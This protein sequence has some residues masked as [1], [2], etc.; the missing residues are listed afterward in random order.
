[1]KKFLTAVCA[2]AAASLF[3]GLIG[4]NGTP[5]SQ[6]AV[7]ADA[8]SSVRIAATEFRDFARRLCG[9]EL[10]VV[11]TPTDGTAVY[12]GDSPALRA[13]G[14]VP[15]AFPDEGYLIRTYRGNL[16]I[17]GD[18][19]TGPLMA[20]GVNPF[21]I[22]ETY[23]PELN[24]S[25]F[26]TAGTMTGVYEFLHR[27][28]NVRF[29]WPGESGIVLDPVP[30]L[31]LTELDLTG[32]PK[33][34]YRYPWYSFFEVDKEGILWARRIGIGAKA[35]VMIMHNYCDFL[36]YKDTHPEYF[37][38]ADGKRAFGAECVADGLGH[39]CLTNPAV[40]R[41]WADDIIA[42]FEVNPTI[43]VY[44][45]VPN[46]GLNRICECPDCQAEVRP[47]MG[48]AGKYSYHIWNF[49]AKVAAL[50]AE[51]FP[52]KY[53]GNIAYSNFRTPPE[54]LGYLPNTV[55]MFCNYRSY[56]AN[57]ELSET[58]HAEIEA[59]SAKSDRIYMW[60]W[61]LDHWLP[62]RGLPVVFSDTIE[63]ELNYMFANPKFAGEFIE[64]ESDTNNFDSMSMPAMQHWSL[65]LT[66]R[67]NWEP[68][69]TAES[70]FNEYCTRFY[71]PA[72]EPM[73]DFWR[74]AELRRN[75]LLAKSA[76]LTPDELF[77]GEFIA[78]LKGL[79]A[80]AVDATE[81]DSIYRQRIETVADEFEIGAGRLVRLQAVGA[82]Q[83]AIPEI[84]GFDDFN[85][86][87]PVRFV[88]RDGEERNPPTWLYT[89]FDRQYLYMLFLCYEPEMD[90]LK[91][92]A[93]PPDDGSIWVDDCLEIFLCPDESD[94]KAPCYQLIVNADG[95]LYDCI[96]RRLN[97][98]V[99]W[100]S[101]AQVRVIRQANRWMAAIRVPF[102]A[103]GVNDPY[104]AGSMAGNFYRSRAVNPLPEVS[105]W[106]PTGELNHYSPEKFG[107]ISLKQD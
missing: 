78:E 84:A 101:Q 64:S 14:F 105:A 92:T 20:G 23:N 100:D 28:G 96:N 63:N 21:R 1:M 31:R 8:P 60:T 83:M 30:E 15:P 13:T 74:N 94:R 19:Y 17:M 97:D 85:E 48:P 7:A 53:V 50:V 88:G 16:V 41:Q 57:P 49:T 47:D 3:A 95:V 24:L 56:L 106:S 22:T 34:G 36:K 18:D 26:G 66:H 86:M 87:S 52:D 9:A 99:P 76:K 25:I 107:V 46:D 33:T 65:Y 69:A 43:E 102:A 90:K 59:W 44:P 104:F 98:T 58:L 39:L 54:E 77:T 32:A 38:L 11:E 5:Y 12:I 6:I 40:I 73:H 91:T 27:V 29:Y 10:T 82:Q 62:W 4:P 35:P 79:L 89:G 2:F 71:G 75:Q 68:E 61:Y 67:L 51:R 72:A 103:I 45:L 42:Y 80:R 81:P 55:V 93:N 70:L 37:A